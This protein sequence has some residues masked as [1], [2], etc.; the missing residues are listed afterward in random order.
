MNSPG[1]TLKASKRDPCSLINGALAAI[2][3]CG[4][5]DVKDFNEFFDRLNLGQI[6]I[7]AHKI[8]T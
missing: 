5:L 8:P 1:R 6:D 4:K 3:F 2:K 7:F